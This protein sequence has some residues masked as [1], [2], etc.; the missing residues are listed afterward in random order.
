MGISELWKGLTAPRRQFEVRPLVA[1]LTLV[2]SPRQTLPFKGTR[3]P[4]M[5][6]S[7]PSTYQS[8]YTRCGAQEEDEIPKCGYAIID[9]YAELD[10]TSSKLDSYARLWA[11][12]DTEFSKRTIAAFGYAI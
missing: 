2:S 9:Y 7:S 6:S 1:L 8:G 12:K 3:T 5:P 10:V 11:A 4:K